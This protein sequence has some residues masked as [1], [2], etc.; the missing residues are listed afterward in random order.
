[1]KSR[2]LIFGLIVFS[3]CYF[4]EEEIPD[5][6]PWKYG[7]PSSVDLN[8]STLFELDD[9][10]R[11]GG[12]D[13]I[14][15]VVAIK[16]DKLI[17]E[18]YYE[19][20]DRETE[21]FLSG[22]TMSVM[23]ML[24]GIA[25]DRGFLDSVQ[26]PINVF[27]P[28][29]VD[30]FNFE[31]LKG[32][33]T[34]EH[35]LLMKSGFAWYETGVPA[36]NPNNSL[37]G[38]TASN[39]WIEHALTRDIDAIPGLRYAYNSTHGVLLAK[40]LERASGQPFIDYVNEVLFTPMN[41]GSASWQSDAFNNVNGGFGLSLNLIDFAKLGDLYLNNGVWKGQRLV[42]EEW[43]TTS[44]SQQFQIDR[45][46]NFGYSWQLFSELSAFSGILP[47][48]DTYFAEGAGGQYLFV[49]PHQNFVLAVT[50]DN[51]FENGFTPLIIFRDFFAEAF[52]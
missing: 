46:S 2:L 43:V 45:F 18:N 28:D 30:A 42:S 34:V 51:F 26:T 33:I 35:L 24:T 40:I 5:T 3:S 12:F 8:E 23:S 37:N 50:A 44:T 25:L 6:A 19:G 38:L 49:V 14:R 15:G 41:I 27:F 31:P 4:N 9:N 17:F 21:Q 16:D 13:Q 52:Q 1:M 20:G 48:N 32:E 39:D 47:E 36:L 22:A 11:Q 29:Y 7:S 10:L